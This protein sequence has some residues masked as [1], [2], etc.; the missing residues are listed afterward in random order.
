MLKNRP[1]IG[2]T[3]PDEGGFAAWI[4]TALSIIIAGGLPVRIRPGRPMSINN[5]SGLIIG[6]GADVDP[7]AYEEEDF[8]N[9]YLEGTIKS[10]KKNFWQRSFRFI[11]FFSYPFIFFTRK[12][13]SNNSCDLDKDRDHLEFNLLD[14]AVKKNLPILGICRGAQLI[15][16]YFKGSLYP[17]IKD[18][19]SE[20]VNKSSILPIKKV[21]VRPHSL[22]H[23]I[24]N[25]ESIKVNSLHHQAVKTPG[26]NILIVGWENSGLVQAIEST[27]YPFI[28]GVQWHPEYLIRKPQ[29]RKI[30][31][32]LILKAKSITK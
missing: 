11:K 6:G 31:K 22:L 30:F 5:L 17:E 20:D 14:N 25:T 4:F 29:H 9:C 2:V 32:A 7:S 8:I 19:Y 21:N 15:N 1:K 3:G 12:L 28:L 10:K 27:C 18:F 13:F 26:E 23:E 24:L 16:V